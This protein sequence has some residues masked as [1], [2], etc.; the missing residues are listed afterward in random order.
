MR[1]FLAWVCGI[2]ISLPSLCLAQHNES[3]R[4][5]SMMVRLQQELDAGK[6]PLLDQVRIMGLSLM[7]A[8]IHLLARNQPR[9]YCAPGRLRIYPKDYAE[10]ALNQ[11]KLNKSFYDNF[12]RYELG[13]VVHALIVGLERTYPCPEK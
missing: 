12:V 1:R 6:G 8:N 10:M 3:V 11:Y 7:A 9:L 13:D 2:V 4:V 5:N